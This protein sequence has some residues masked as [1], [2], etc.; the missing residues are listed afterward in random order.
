MCPDSF[1]QIYILFRA[2]H[3]RDAYPSFNNAAE[4]L[5]RK[6]FG[7]SK[8]ANYPRYSKSIIREG[9][10]YGEMYKDQFHNIRLTEEGLVNLQNLIE[11]HI[12]N[13]SDLIIPFEQAKVA[14]PI[15]A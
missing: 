14:K 3:E 13:C 6:V 4:S 9:M 7:T 15:P 1:K 8:F 10:Q 12:Q 5:S 2:A 11:S